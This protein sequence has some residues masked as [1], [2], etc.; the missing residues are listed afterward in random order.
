LFSND[1]KQSRRVTFEDWEQRPWAEKLQERV[2]SLLDSQ[3]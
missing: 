3:L 2:E 1:L